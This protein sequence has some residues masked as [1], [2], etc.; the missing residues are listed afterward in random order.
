MTRI[1]RSDVNHMGR[2]LSFGCSAQS[3]RKNRSFKEKA[4]SNKEES[5]KSRKEL[6]INTFWIDFEK[7]KQP[8]KR[9]ILPKA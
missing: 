1:L 9:K 4:A 3:D 5:T 7:K 6:Q 8:A 2:I